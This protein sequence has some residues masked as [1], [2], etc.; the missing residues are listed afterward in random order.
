MEKEQLEP[1][2]EQPIHVERYSDKYKEQVVELIN[3]IMENGN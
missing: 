3:H 2:E 1:T